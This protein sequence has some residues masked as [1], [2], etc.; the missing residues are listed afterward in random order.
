MTAWHALHHIE[1][2]Q[3]GETVL[4]HSG[5]G[6]TG[7]AAIQLAQ[8][9]GATIFT[10]VGMERKK[11][12]LAKWYNIPENQIFSSRDTVFVKSIKRLTSGV[13]VDVVLSSLSGEGLTASWEC[14]A[15]YGRFIEI[16]KED[17]LLHSKLQMSHFAQ[18][19]MFTAVDVAA[20]SHERPLMVRRALEAIFPL[21]E[22]G[23]L[24]PAEPIQIYGVSEIENAFR[25]IQS[26]KSSGKAVVELRPD[27]YVQVRRLSLLN[28]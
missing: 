3:P 5:A 7:Q 23:I 12:F 14:I 6:G 4:I 2:V 11:G 28:L 21:V 17:I 16:G 8:H 10:T 25:H 18:N 26:G 20:M 24:T 15:P 9:M 13:G 19:V 22:E 1:R 27:D